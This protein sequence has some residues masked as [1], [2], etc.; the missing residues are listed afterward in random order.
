M[1]LF[2][3]KESLI[4]KVEEDDLN[5]AKLSSLDFAD[6]A[7]KKR[8]FINVL[9]ARL[10][11]KHLFSKKIQANN[12]YSLYTIHSILEELDIADIY[13]EG[14]KID[15]RLV[16]NRNE[17]FIPKSH[18]DYNLLPDLYLIFELTEDF[19]SV[20][21]LGH[22]EP[23]ELNKELA[24]NSFYFFEYENLTDPKDLKTTL[25]KL[26]KE[27]KDKI[28]APDLEKARELFL[29][30]V[31]KE[32][33]RSD[34]LFLFKQ[35]A[36]SLSLREEMIEFE[37]FE[38]ISKETAKNDDLFKD[39]ILSIVGTQ[40][41]Y[42][43]EP[44]DDISIEDA[45]AEFAELEDESEDNFE[46]I[47]EIDEESYDIPENPQNDND[48]NRDNGGGFAAGAVLGAAAAG[49]VAAGAIA[50]ASM[51][52]ATT[53]AAQSAVVA[54]KAIEAGAEV[55]SQGLKTVS[56]IIDTAS[57]DND[58]DINELE[59]LVNK[60]GE[61]TLSENNELNL[62]ELDDL[63]NNNSAEETVPEETEENFEEE[64]NELEEIGELEEFGELEE[65]EEFEEE[66][67]TSSDNEIEYGYEEQ[68][69]QTD[70]EDSS[71]VV[72]LDDFDIDTT[73]ETIEGEEETDSPEDLLSFD[74]A[75]E[76]DN[77]IEI[78]AET[79]EDD[80]E[81]QTMKKIK[82]LE[83][84]E[85]QEE[86]EST[87]LQED[88]QNNPDE[89]ISQVDDFLNEIEFSDEQKQLLESSFANENFDDII[90]IEEETME[91]SQQVEEDPVA[92]GVKSIA[93]DPLQVLFDEEQ[94]KVSAQ[95]AISSE[96]TEADLETEVKSYGILSDKD[97]IVELFNQNKKMVIAASVAGIVIATF[98]V[99]SNVIKKNQQAIAQKNAAQTPIAAEG[100]APGDL[101][102]DPNM[103]PED[104]Q[105]LSGEGLNAS[106]PQE[107][108]GENPQANASRDMGKAVSDA[109]LSEPVNATI[110][111]VAWEVPEDL[112]YN[113]SFRKYLQIAG[114]NLKLNLQND[115][116]LTN[117]M[118]YS[119]KV[120][121]DLAINKDGS[122]QSSNITVSSGSQ[123]I[124]KIVLQSVKDTLKYLK[125]PSSELSSNSANMTLIINF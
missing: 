87:E 124:D 114:K 44:E 9:G 77:E 8:A 35:L 122:L 113:D 106:G 100:Q 45:F 19:S 17:I 123:Q 115:L 68:N 11:M 90:N 24:N 6:N 57:E 46:V 47:D 79:E 118:S 10:A 70:T 32:I 112:A 74:T 29:S 66:E 58:F 53:A 51:S 73:A 31:D 84:L 56:N 41:L 109:F 61:E 2:D 81:L 20:E 15:V 92:K 64:E 65:L 14:I 121:V 55:L 1:G 88:T 89:I 117:E 59:D 25:D 91:D 95:S 3:K 86:N 12:I 18:F 50:A 101:M 99:G 38:I 5:D 33:S 39:G 26:K 96:I 22:F 93:D 30:L 28:F 21:F 76:N 119:N 37:N 85:A 80:K 4:I 120:V 103:I 36:E 94:S 48:D 54:E 69:S 98:A 49:S 102:Q 107:I 71:E 110:S 67:E 63:L 108:P 97:K 43:N 82:E 27:V 104:A 83:D 52:S 111:K 125:M 78:E 116:L 16:F 34:K 62:D 42:E 75:N 23:Q 105:G 7:I 60:T 40:D 72:N 13:F